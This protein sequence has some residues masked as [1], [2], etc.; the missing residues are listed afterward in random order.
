MLIYFKLLLTAIIWGGTFISGRVLSGMIG[1]FSAACLRFASASIFL[2]LVTCR[3]EHHPPRL[4][5]ARIPGILALGLTGIAAYNFF[6]F[7]GLKL[8]PASRAALIISLNPVAIAVC[9]ALILR[10]R[11]SPL[12]ALGVLISVT[13]AATV[14][15]RG[16]PSAILHA[17]L[18]PGE[19]L[20][21]GCVAS[22]TT[23]SLLGKKVLAN[24]T[25]LSAVTWSSIAG[26]AMLL[27]FALHEGLLH[28]APSLPALGWMHI[29]YLG[30]AGTGLGFC[31]FYEGIRR[32]GTA[33]A[34]VFINFVPASGVLLG[35]LILDEPISFSLLAGAVLV[36]TGVSLTNRRT[37]AR[38]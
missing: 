12:N 15:S 37:P 29:L 17:G 32:L 11:L 23:Y 34:G 6:F 33:R 38:S 19:L 3:T 35:W 5:P 7:S 14:I 25:P 18:G 13:G 21:L 20:I 1:P 28:A 16:D 22:W 27:P 10:E 30:V 4:D 2:V 26:T 36:I 9:S 31:W 24:I 8:I